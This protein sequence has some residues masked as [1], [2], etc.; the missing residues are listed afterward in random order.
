LLAGLGLVS[1]IDPVGGL[2]I[3]MRRDWNC[4]IEQSGTQQKF[5]FASLIGI[6]RAVAAAFD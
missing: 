5:E 2:L 6:G 1:G 3:E 4:G